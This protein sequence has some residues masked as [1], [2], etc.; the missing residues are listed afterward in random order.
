MKRLARAGT[1]ALGLLTWVS[2]VHA[3]GDSVAGRKIAEKHCSRCHVIGDYNPSG[4]IGSTP[5]FQLLAKRSD[6]LERFQTFFERRPHP[7]FVRVPG[8]PRWTNL[9]AYAAEFTVRLESIDDLIA[10]VELLRPKQPA[11][12]ANTGVQ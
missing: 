3:Q 12:G 1:V 2:G 10:F 5:S 6:Y 11:R 4:G 7:V 8:I 9:P